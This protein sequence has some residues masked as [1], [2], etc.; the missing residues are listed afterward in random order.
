M[1][2]TAELLIPALA[3]LSKVC[4]QAKVNMAVTRNR[5]QQQIEYAPVSFLH[6]WMG[7]TGQWRHGSIVF[8]GAKGQSFPTKRN[9]SDFAILHEM[10]Q[11]LTKC[12]FFSQTI[13]RRSGRLN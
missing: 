6:F 1:R 2:V 13:R 11:T 5:L 12:P 8:G 3:L 4:K 7:H 10:V 9:F